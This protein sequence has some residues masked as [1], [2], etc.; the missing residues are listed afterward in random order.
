MERKEEEVM[1]RKGGEKVR[2]AGV[3]KSDTV[4][5]EFDKT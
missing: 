2:N 3:M 5:G 1:Q 4:F